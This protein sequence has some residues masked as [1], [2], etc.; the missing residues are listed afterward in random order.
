VTS[1]SR[2]FA[3]VIVSVAL[4]PTIVT[5]QGM[6]GSVFRHE[7]DVTKQQTGPHDGGGV[8]TYADY[9]AGLQPRPS[10]RFVERTLHPGSTIGY[11]PQPTDEVFYIVAGHGVMTLDGRDINVQ[12]G[13]AMLTRPGSS[14][15]LKP[16][17]GDLTIVVAEAW[18]DAA[19]D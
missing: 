14:H 4:L 3:V 5:S 8:T 10:F 1:T 18:P 6:S 9:F 16:V 12:A 11:H 17:G 19:K 13:D 15:G 2:T 7:A